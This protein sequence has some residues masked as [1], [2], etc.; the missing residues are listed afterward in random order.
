MKP[1]FAIAAV[2]AAAA[3]PALAGDAADRAALLEAY[4]AEAGAADAGF[5][6]FSAQRGETLFRTR[7]SG[8]DA[9]TPSCTACH[10]DD[11]RQPGRNAKTGRPIEPVAVSVAPS[12]FTDPDE[13]EK[14][15]RRDC[16]AVLGRA[17][18]PLEKG[19]YITFMQEQ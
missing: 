11:P 5:A 19:D 6:G 10:T 3:T 1:L 7:W 18:T 14:Q 16:D 2:L 15:F 13:V 8:G 17:C 4:A 9:R 12:R